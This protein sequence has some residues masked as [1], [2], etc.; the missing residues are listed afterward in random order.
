MKLIF[1]NVDTQYDFIEDKK[2]KGT[3]VIPESGL[4][5]PS[6]NLLTQYASNRG[7]QVVNT[8]D[9]HDKKSQEIGENPD[10]INIFPRH[11]MAGTFGVK[12][13]PET[14]PKNPVVITWKDKRFDRDEILKT[15]NLVLY[16]D[17][18]SVFN[19]NKHTDKIIETISPD[20]AVVYGVATDVCVKYAVLGLQQRGV[21]CYVALDAIKGI[22]PE[23]SDK[24]L[25]EMTNAGAR[26]VTT[27]DV[28]E[29]RI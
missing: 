24:A 17:H 7:V 6:L 5:R 27:Q 8:G 3:L 12:F 18:F 20:E 16:K 21:Q 1:W 10:Y 15:R 2:Y 4:I 19:G 13:I 28:L 11:C 29:G 26:F 14:Q 9:W 23:S 25:E 22:T